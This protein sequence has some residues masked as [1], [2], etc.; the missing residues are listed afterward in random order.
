[1]ALQI[2]VGIFFQGAPKKRSPFSIALGALITERPHEKNPWTGAD[3]AM[4]QL[5]RGCVLE[6][7]GI[8]KIFSDKIEAFLIF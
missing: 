8:L 2:L 4:R 5:S 3:V 7:R 6:M 1:M